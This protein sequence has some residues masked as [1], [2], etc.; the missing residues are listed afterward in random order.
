MAS[1]EDRERARQQADQAAYEAPPPSAFLVEE[2]ARLGRLAAERSPELN[3]A[4]IIFSVS[5]LEHLCEA[6]SEEVRTAWDRVRSEVCIVEEVDCPGDPD[7]AG[8][9]T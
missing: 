3:E 5:V 7:P 1:Y 9:S 2:C 8:S 6:F 4:A